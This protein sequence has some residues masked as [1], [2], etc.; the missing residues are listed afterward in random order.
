MLQIKTKAKNALMSIFAMIFTVLT[1]GTTAFAETADVP[2]YL[3]VPATD[4]PVDIVVDEVSTG[5]TAIIFPYIIAAGISV[6]IG[7]I[8]ISKNFQKRITE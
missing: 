6:L 8:L 7:F 1:A 3:T 4:I 2:V 5:D